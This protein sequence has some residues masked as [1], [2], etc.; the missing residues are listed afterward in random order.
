MQLFSIGLFMLNQDGTKVIDE[1]TGKP[2]DTYSNDDIVNFSRGWT[3][4][5]EREE[6]RDNI[7]SE[8]SQVSEIRLICCVMFSFDECI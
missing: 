8:W 5:N 2:V 4:F 7:E 1:V 3:N 6:Q